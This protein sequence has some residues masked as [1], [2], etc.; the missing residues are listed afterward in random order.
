MKKTNYRRARLA[1]EIK[2]IV[3]GLLQTELKDPRF[4]GIVSVSGAEVTADGGCAV[5]YISVL[6][7]MSGENAD[8][9][10]KREIL[11]AFRGAGGFLRKE[12]GARLRL[13]RTPELL[14]RLDESQEYGRHIE[15]IIN[16]LGIRPDQDESGADGVLPQTG[17][18]TE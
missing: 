8:E 1:G 14:F 9:E 17:S 4:F 2:R 13:R 12:V 16:D 6:G 3:G 15:R 10:K 18:D 5:L 7:D 11:E